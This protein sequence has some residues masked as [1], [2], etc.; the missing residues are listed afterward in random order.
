MCS[1][2]F[3]GGGRGGLGGERRGSLFDM[4]SDVAGTNGSAH[5]EL[6]DLVM[7]DLDSGDSAAHEADLLERLDHVK[8]ALGLPADRPLNIV[9]LGA[10]AWGSVFISMLQKQYRKLKG[11]VYFSIYRREG[12]SLSKDDA[13]T[14]LELINENPDVIRRLRQKGRY[15]KYVDGR[16]GERVLK[17]DEVLTDGFCVN[18][19]EM[20]LIPLQ[21]WVISFPIIFGK[22]LRLWEVV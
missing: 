13:S 10:G 9:G 11:K 19:L 7:D 3:W 20:P 5:T 14:I 22:Y 12:K 6:K 8:L 1:L 15:F 16:L 18:M 21:V 17:A 4:D 2:F